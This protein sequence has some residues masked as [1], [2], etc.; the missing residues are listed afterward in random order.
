VRLGRLHTCPVLYT[1]SRA[2]AHAVS[3]VNTV[4]GC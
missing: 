1:R 3:N 2:A 4:A